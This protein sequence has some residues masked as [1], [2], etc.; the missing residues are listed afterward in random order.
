LESDLRP[1]FCF[2]V[3]S[4]LDWLVQLKKRNDCII[5]TDNKMNLFI[6]ISPDI[7]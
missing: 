5:I 3:S 1:S 2:S 7:L 4:I 6:I